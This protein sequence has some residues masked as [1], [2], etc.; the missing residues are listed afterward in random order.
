MILQLA[1]GLILILVCVSVPVLYM[2][3]YGYLSGR[4]S[5]DMDTEPEDWSSNPDIPEIIFQ[6][7]GLSSTFPKK[8]PV[9]HGLD[10]SSDPA[11]TPPPSPVPHSS[12]FPMGGV[13]L[14]KWFL[15]V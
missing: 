14:S 2:G 8:N 11:T 13:A 1:L 4:L 3:L 7:S 10:L 12:G 9:A 15:M 6:S 5:K